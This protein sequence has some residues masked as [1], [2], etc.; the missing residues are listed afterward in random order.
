MEIEAVEV[1]RLELSLV[2]AVATSMGT[3]ASRP[4]LIVC[5]HSKGGIGFG[6]CSALRDPTYTEEYTDGAEAI[7]AQHLIPR[8][9]EGAARVDSAEQGLLRCAVVQGHRMA[10]AALEMAMLDA[11]L[12]EERRSLASFL[13]A[14][15]SLVQAGATIGMG[16]DETTSRAFEKAVCDGYKR[17]KLKIAPGR[18]VAITK[19][20]R[21]RFPDVAL[22]VDANGAYDRTLA[23]HL[24][25]LDALDEL[26][27]QGI[28]Q[29]LA[30]SDLSGHARLS[31]RLTTPVILDESIWDE[32]A[33]EVAL[34]L[35]AMDGVSVKAPRLG[36]LIAARRVHDRCV[37]EGM[38]LA[39]G[40]MFETGIG[41][42]AQ[43]ALGGLPGFD[44]PG[45]LGASDRYF[46]KDLTARHEIRDGYLAVPGGVGLGVEVDLEML[47]GISVKRETF[48]A[49]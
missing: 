40:G 42:A 15:R 3:H 24:S 31:A 38:H 22:I 41:R 30:P 26:G 16:D 23:T 35:H 32:G 36:G 13:G 18:D 21:A 9:F 5:V 48:R 49:P 20:L 6:E 7:L 17:V 4:V 46:A 8:L 34:E 19:V 37:E 27:L 28:E 47:R 33:L 1:L 43:L 25:A 12:R 2:E 44:L 45:D 39:I 11:Q 14:T 29:P 10:K